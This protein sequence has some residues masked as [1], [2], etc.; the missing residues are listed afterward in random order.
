MQVL[1]DSTDAVTREL[2][3]EKVGGW[4]GLGMGLCRG[5]ANAGIARCGSTPCCAPLLAH[6]A[7]RLCCSALLAVCC[8]CL[9]SKRLH[10]HVPLVS[11]WAQVLEWRERGVN[12]EC[13]RRTNRQGY[14]AGAM[15]EV[16]TG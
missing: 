8:G 2:V 16:R 15:K 11:P 4:C 6:V 12:V 14:K 10:S 9:H 1:D 3:D 7:A 13:V 5:G